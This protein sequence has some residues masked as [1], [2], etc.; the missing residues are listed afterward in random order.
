MRQFYEPVADTTS[1]VEQEKLTWPNILSH[2]D[3]IE[4]DFHHFYGVDLDEDKYRWGKTWKWFN[5]RLMRLLSE[6]T[7]IERALD[8]FPERRAVPDRE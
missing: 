1:G 7:A 2:W 6:E 3:A 4:T 5:K 8:L